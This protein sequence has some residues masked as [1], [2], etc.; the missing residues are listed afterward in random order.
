MFVRCLRGGA[1]P[2]WL[3]VSGRLP[4]DIEATRLGVNEVTL[5]SAYAGVGWL[6]LSF[7]RRCRDAADKAHGSPDDRRG[8]WL[9][10][11]V[12]A[13]GCRWEEDGPGNAAGVVCRGGRAEP[14]TVAATTP[15]TLLRVAGGS[16]GFRRVLGVGLAALRLQAVIQLRV[17]HGL[18]ARDDVRAVFARLARVESMAKR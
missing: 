7:P 10:V 12:V 3:D 8:D 14:A 1:R 2:T 9:H 16:L 18:G 4:T 13:G 5:I 15:S 17:A 6:P 11:A